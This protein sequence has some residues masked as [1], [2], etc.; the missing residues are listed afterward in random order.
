M[1]WCSALRSSTRMTR[2]KSVPNT[3]WPIRLSFP[4]FFRNLVDFVQSMQG[5]PTVGGSSRS[6]RH[7]P[8]VRAANRWRWCA[9]SGREFPL[10]DRQ[11][12]LFQQTEEIGVYRVVEE[13]PTPSLA[14]VRRQSVQPPGEQPRPAQSLTTTWSEVAGTPELK[15]QRVEAWPLLVLLAIVVLI[16]EWM[17]YQQRTFP[18]DR[19]PW[20]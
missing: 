1:I 4:V 3:D 10:A 19:T 15:T 20:P 12:F 13:T 8:C 14:A 2:E 9:P 17:V 18:T 16:V 11:P 5:Q 6:H 7:D